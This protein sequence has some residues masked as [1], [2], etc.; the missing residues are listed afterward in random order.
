MLRRVF[1]WSMPACAYPTRISSG[2]HS[3]RCSSRRSIT[4]A[5]EP[6]SRERGS[7]KSQSSFASDPSLLAGIEKYLHPAHRLVVGE[8]RHHPRLGVASGLFHRS[9]H[10]GAPHDRLRLSEPEAAAFHAGSDLGVDPA[11]LGDAPHRR[12]PV[13]GLEPELR[14]HRHR[15]VGRHRG[16]QRRMGLL[17][18]FRRH[19]QPDDPVAVL[20]IRVDG[21]HRV[22]EA[23]LG[24]GKA[25]VL[26]LVGEELLRPG[27]LD[28]L[29][30]LDEERPVL[31]LLRV[32]VGVE[33]GALVAADAASE[34]HLDA[35]L[36]QVIEDGDVLREADGMPPHRDVGHLPYAN[37]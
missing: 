12:L 15:A 31:L 22:T 1:L 35:S 10:V 27:L 25:V 11:A 9:R 34:A 16:P 7:R 32:R 18:G 26:A 19:P 33:L 30:G 37:S 3:S 4:W 29:D 20:P 36:R 13:A 21:I 14:R 6:T 8:D 2:R 5:G 28:D 24:G 23:G 17:E